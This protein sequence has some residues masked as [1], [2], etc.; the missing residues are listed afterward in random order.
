MKAIQPATL[1]HHVAHLLD[2]GKVI[3]SNFFPAKD[4]ENSTHCCY[5]RCASFI[6]EQRKCLGPLTGT[7]HYYAQL[8]L[9]R[10]MSCNQRMVVWLVLLNLIPKVFGRKRRDL[11]FLSYPWLL[12]LTLECHEQHPRPYVV[13]TLI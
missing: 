5:V 2:D 11:A 1:A 3:G 13:N 9:F 10:Q 4:V 6:V 8:G 12:N 7:T